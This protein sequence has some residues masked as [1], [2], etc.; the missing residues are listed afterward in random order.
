MGVT[1]QEG[2]LLNSLF[3]I[4]SHLALILGL[5]CPLG[6]EPSSEPAQDLHSPIIFWL[7]CLALSLAFEQ[8]LTDQPGEFG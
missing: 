6:R 4:Y 2:A 3:S 5:S 8:K 7:L 1:F